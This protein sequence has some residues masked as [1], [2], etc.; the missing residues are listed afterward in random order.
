[1]MVDI[2]DTVSSHLRMF[3]SKE[4]PRG[5]KHILAILVRL[6]PGGWTYNLTLVPD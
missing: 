3:Q 2:V 5:R 4:I 1:M 6:P